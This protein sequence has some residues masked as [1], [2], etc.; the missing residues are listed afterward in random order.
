MTALVPR[1]TGLPDRAARAR[2]EPDWML[3]QLP[4]AM[5]DATG[6]D[7]FVRFV[8]IFQELGSTLLADA[9]NIENIVDVT[10]APDEMVRWLGSWIGLSDMV[11]H[12]DPSVNDHLQRRIVR[13][14]AKTLAWRGTAQGLTEF[15]ELMSNGPARVVEGG[16]VWRDGEAPLDTAWVRL[17]VDSTGYLDQADFVTVIR[18]EVPAHVRVELYVS[19]QCVWSSDEESTP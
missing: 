13:S 10:V 16:G 3:R 15:L 8:S 19:G 14:A 18:D 4:V 11:E 9:D 5:I 12:P 7:L 1:T 6:S 17:E 2:R